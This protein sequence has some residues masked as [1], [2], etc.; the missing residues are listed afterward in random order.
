MSLYCLSLTIKR[1]SFLSDTYVLTTLPASLGKRPF[2]KI[3]HAALIGIAIQL[4]VQFPI[5]AVVYENEIKS[6][7]KKMMAEGR[8][9]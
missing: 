8:L 1:I 2:F 5:V 3:S 4:T 6:K 9:I 7:D